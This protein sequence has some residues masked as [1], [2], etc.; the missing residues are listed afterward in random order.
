M[1]NFLLF[2]K[3]FSIQIF[4]RCG[5]LSITKKLTGSL[6]ILSF[7]SLIQ[8]FANTLQ[9]FRENKSVYCSNS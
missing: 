1:N 3:R 4:V 2:F 7:E 9:E 8:T 6:K 5:L